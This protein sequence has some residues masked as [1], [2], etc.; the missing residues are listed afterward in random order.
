MGFPIYNI[1]F[2][3]AVGAAA[4]A[5]PIGVKRS[6]FLQ[7]SALFK[8]NHF[9]LLYCLIWSKCLL[10]GTRYLF[11]SLMNVRNEFSFEKIGR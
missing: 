2:A 6:T 5:P 8:K 11:I 10:N 9:M 4:A 3:V 7:H 1:A